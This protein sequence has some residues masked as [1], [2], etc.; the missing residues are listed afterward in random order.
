MK[1][2]GGTKHNA[3]F[4]FNAK[5]GRHP[6]TRAELDDPVMKM[7]V[8]P[9]VKMDIPLEC[10][11][12]GQWEGINGLKAI[13]ADKRIP[14]EKDW[15]PADMEDAFQ[16]LYRSGTGHFRV[17]AD[18][19]KATQQHFSMPSHVKWPDSM[20]LLSD[21]PVY[22][23]IQPA[24]E[25]HRKLFPYLTRNTR[26]FFMKSE[27]WTKG[28]GITGS[29]RVYKDGKYELRRG[30]KGESSSEGTAEAQSRPV[31]D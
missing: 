8:W 27:S 22:F 26:S 25:V 3:L 9:K 6:W 24:T 31:Q 29:H 19:N 15:E 5:V 10:V 14:T 11:L 13:L 17:K 7:G 18:T 30:N 16:P 1:V 2:N 28:I 4:H 12:V 23:R 21:Q 20:S